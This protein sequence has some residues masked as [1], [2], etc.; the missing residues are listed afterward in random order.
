MGKSICKTSCCTRDKTTSPVWKTTLPASQAYSV[1]SYIDKVMD[2]QTGLV[3]DIRQEIML[4]RFRNTTNVIALMY[5]PIHSVGTRG[6]SSGQISQG[7][8]V[9][10]RVQQ[11]QT[12]VDEPVPM[13]K[14]GSP[15]FVSRKECLH[16]N[17][18][19]YC[20]ELGHQLAGC[21]K[22][23]SRNHPR[24]PSLGQTFR[25]HQSSFRRVMEEDVDAEDDE[26]VLDSM[27]LNMVSMETTTTPARGLLR[28][29]GIMNSQSIRVLIE[30]GAE[31]NFVRPGLG[32][33]HTD[34]AKVPAE[35]RI[36][37]QCCEILSF[38]DR[39]FSGVTLIEWDVS[40]N[41]YV[42]LGIPCLLQF[43]PIINCQTG[44]M[45]FPTQRWKWS[46]IRFSIFYHRCYGSNVIITSRQGTSTR[47]WG[48]VRSARNTTHCVN[49]R[50]H[51][52]QRRSEEYPELYHVTVKTSPTLKTIL[53]PLR[54]VLSEF[55]DVF[56]DEQSAQLP[57]P[58]P[59]EQEV[60]LKQGAKPNN[61]APFRLSKVAQE[62]L[63]L[64][65]P[66][67]LRQNWIQVSDSPWVSNIFGVPSKDPVTGK[68]PFRLEWLHSNNP[69]MPIRWVID[70]RLVNAASDVAKIHLPHIEEL[71]DLME[72]VF[73]ILD[74][75]SG[76][77]QIRISPTSKQYT[78]FC[79]N[80]EI[81]EWN[82]APMGLAGIPGTWTRRMWQL[83]HIFRFAMVYLDDIY[84]FS[85]SMADYIE[86][87]RENKL[88]ARPDKSDFGQSSVDFLGHTISSR[89]L[90][91]DARKTRAIAE[92]PEPTNT[93][94][95]Q[96]FL[97]LAGYYR[98]FIHH[99]ADMVL[100]LSGLVKK[101][102]FKAIKLALQQSPV[103][104]SPDFQKHFV[105]T[106]DAS[107]ACIGGV[108][109]QIHDGA[110]LPVAFFSKKLGAHELNWPVHEKELFAIK[111]A[112]TS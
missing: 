74:L 16:N 97:G 26:E 31:R 88:Y 21:R 22:R 14:N 92:W 49:Y 32:Q 109:S 106:T 73:S 1:R 103:L 35:L 57:P 50:Y 27:Q 38:A 112:L 101:D 43:N 47:R 46:L 69:N 7:A 59:I 71:F 54:G 19:F 84:F 65:F 48:P 89:G 75:A 67:L 53:H 110:A 87:L 76:Y 15:C 70:Y 86:H 39:D 17:L 40:A 42:I 30:S 90:R 55:A 13:E 95:L 10:R 107:H 6:K 108:L 100:P 41:Q 91:G 34:A 29:D 5:A 96:R 9:Q 23:Q 99:F 72:D 61:C 3:T 18:C 58:R 81:Y 20:K 78:A 28:F 33:H 105:V 44:V 83:L 24:D 4:R 98:R 79:T 11:Q 63:D 93:K 2:F 51:N 45:Q 37:E 94:E 85:R 56:P 8:L 66:D 111:Q 104:R 80:L 12:Y 60:V 36:A 82:V 77:H 102:A 25:T 62:A 68:F 64:F 52:L